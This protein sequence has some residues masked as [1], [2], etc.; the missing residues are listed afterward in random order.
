MPVTN[1]NVTIP[2]GEAYSPAFDVSNAQQVFIAM[3]GEWSQRA[4]LTFQFSPNSGASWFDV[5]DN[6]GQEVSVPIVTGGAMQLDTAIATKGHIK[7]RS[8]TRKWPIPQDADR[9]FM[10]TVVS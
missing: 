1:I 5:V 9:L 8:G 2:A 7:L 3:S 4:Q 10:I 6:K